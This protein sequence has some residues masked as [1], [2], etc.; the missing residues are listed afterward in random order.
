MENPYG[1]TI[2]TKK[3]RLTNLTTC[4]PISL[5]CISKYGL[6]SCADFGPSLCTPMDL[7]PLVLRSKSR[8][9]PQKNL[10]LVSS[11]S[12]LRLPP[13]RSLSGPILGGGDLAVPDTMAQR[14]HQWPPI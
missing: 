7:H 1:S 2:Q 9:T 10:S 13:D 5:F 6:L 8:K 3:E 14:K 4:R 11:A 12:A